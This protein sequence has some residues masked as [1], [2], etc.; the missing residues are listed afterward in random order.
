MQLQLCKATETTTL[1]NVEWDVD[2]QLTY[3]KI[4]EIKELP[5]TLRNCSA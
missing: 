5:Y 1:P 2:L 4:K 3:V